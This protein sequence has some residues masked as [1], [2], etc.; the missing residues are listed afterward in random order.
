MADAKDVGARVLAGSRRGLEVQLMERRRRADELVDL[1]RRAAA[2]DRLNFADKPRGRP[3]RIARRLAR[4]GVA[5]TERHI[6][7]ILSD[8]GRS[9]S[10][11]LRSN[12]QQSTTEAEP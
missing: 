2:L 6:R 12:G 7:R 4:D 1:V 3:G 8:M 10:D 5:V 9:M 11:S